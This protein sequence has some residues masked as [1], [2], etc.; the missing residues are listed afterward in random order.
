MTYGTYNLIT[1][2]FLSFCGLMLITSVLLFLK[3]KII[4][5]IGDLSGR[6][7]KKQI[8]RFREGNVQ[9]G[10]KKFKPSPLNLERGKLTE[11]MTGKTGK[12]NNLRRLGKTGSTY[13]PVSQKEN[14]A[15][16]ASEIST[17]NIPKDALPNNKYAVG[18]TD[19]LEARLNGTEVLDI[20]TEI[21]DSGAEVRG[22]EV[23]GI[24]C[25]QSN[26]ENMKF[27]VIKSILLIHTDE[28]I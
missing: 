11:A 28:V 3:F 24:S 22:T 20:G 7:A 25:E 8:A 5:V 26:A 23:L 4:S 9:T 17:K 16:I 2:I 6:T 27:V 13:N 10:D 1:I 18:Q 19:V 15:P 14:K 12:D 21:L